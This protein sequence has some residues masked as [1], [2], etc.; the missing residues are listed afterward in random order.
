[1]CHLAF[2]S[3]APLYLAPPME[4][5][6]PARG[7][8]WHPLMVRHRPGA[9]RSNPELTQPFCRGEGKPRGSAAHSPQ[10]LLGG[11]SRCFEDEHAG[12]MN[13]LAASGEE[14]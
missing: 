11:F 12:K 10:R 13:D 4:Y 6:A 7:G 9:F 2:A 5:E 1:M 3:W 8:A 14:S